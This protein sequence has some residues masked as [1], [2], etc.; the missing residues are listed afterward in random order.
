MKILGEKLFAKDAQGRLLSRIGTL[1]FRTP[2]LVTVRGVHATQRLLWIDTLNAERAAKGLPELTPEEVAAELENSV[3]LIMTDEN[4]YIRPDPERM[5]LAF[6]ADEELQKSVSKRRIRYLNTH[7]A[8]VRNALR[9]RGENWR[10]ARQPISQEDMKRLILDSHVSIDHGCIYYYNRN[11]GTRFLTVGGYAE[12]AKLPP[13]EF[14]AQI[15]EVVALFS[16]RN[17]MGNP[18]AEVFPTSTPIEI[19]KSIRSLDIDRLTD[20][21]LR[22]AT[23]KI[24]REWR[25]SLP[26]DLRD[27]NVENFAWRNAMCAVL[28][29]VSSAPEIDGSELIQG[30]SPEFFRQIEWLPGARIDRGELIFDPLW[31]EYARTRDPELGQICDPRVRNIIFNFMRFYRDLQYV[32]VGRIANSLS[33]RPNAEQHRG[34]VYILQLKEASRLDP[35]VAIIRFQ[36]WG[37]AEHLDEGKDL[38]QSILEANDYSDYIMD[39]RLMCQQLGMNLPQYVGSGQFAEPYHGRNQYNGTTVRAYYFIR[40]YMS[41]T[42][43][44]KVPV[45]KFRNPAYALK[46]ARL[47]GGA[48]ALDMIVGRLATKNGENIFDCNYEIVQQGPDGLPEHVAVTDHAGTFVGYLKTFEELVPPYANVVRRRVPYLADVRAFAQAYVTGFKDKLAEVRGKY[49]ERRRAFDDLLVH[50]PFD[51][52]GSGAYRWAK[53]LERLA[54]CDPEEV[55]SLLEKAID[56]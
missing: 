25:M 10:M 18:E 49:L 41:G 24:D 51:A 40:A 48:A 47:M 34:S 38:L 9:A 46:F 4:V 45:A 2:G 11:T 31:D 6:K 52:A 1:F 23:D 21:E 44:D 30:L 17:R 22:R 50:R 36:K 15:R 14:R 39:R 55:A 12:I 7:A 29:R 43:S 42:A 28:T 3:D 54:A 5:D 19:A 26:A 13:A 27:E 53:T 37:V 8:K 16:R 56:A 20:E 33:R 32:N 35:Y